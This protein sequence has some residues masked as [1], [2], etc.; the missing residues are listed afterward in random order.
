M[1]SVLLLSPY[2][3]T[4]LERGIRARGEELGARRLSARGYTA[5]DVWAVERTRQLSEDDHAIMLARL[6]GLTV[7]VVLSGYPS[8]LYDEALAGWHR[9]EKEALADG[10]RKSIEV[11]WINPKA[12]R[13]L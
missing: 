9:V 7:M 4:D 10:A 5:E 8:R 13:A 2:A 1:K 11:L 3:D 12:H 6:Q